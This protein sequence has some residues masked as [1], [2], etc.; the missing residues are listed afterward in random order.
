MLTIL[1]SIMDQHKYNVNQKQ[2]L[3]IEFKIF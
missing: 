3:K 2:K 1:L